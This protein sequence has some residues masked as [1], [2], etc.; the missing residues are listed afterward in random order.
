MRTHKLYFSGL[1]TLTLFRKHHHVGRLGSPD[2][3]EHLLVS[4]QWTVDPQR[5]EWIHQK[6]RQPFAFH[7]QSYHSFSTIFKIIHFR[8]STHGWWVIWLETGPGTRGGATGQLPHLFL[9]GHRTKRIWN[10]RTKLSHFDYNVWKH[11]L[12]RRVLMQ[13]WDKWP[14]CLSK[15]SPKCHSEKKQPPWNLKILWKRRWRFCLLGTT[16]SYNHFSPLKNNIQLVEALF[17]NI[18]QDRAWIAILIALIHGLLLLFTVA[19]LFAKKL[20]CDY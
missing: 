3:L 2:E 18:A 9:F 14:K 13:L 6:L 5:S 1:S 10:D 8:R 12:L 11:R 15:I 17:G 7:Q 20:L 4:K 19:R 16:I